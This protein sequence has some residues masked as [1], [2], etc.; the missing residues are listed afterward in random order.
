VLSGFSLGHADLLRRAM[1]KKIKAEM[2]A[3]RRSFGDGAM[4]R[5]VDEARAGRIFD[6]VDKFA[7]YGFNKSHAAAYALVA[8]QTAWLKANHPVEF[9][10]AS[11]TLDLGNTD[12]LNVFRQELTRLAIPLLP[13]D[14]NDSDVAF[15]VRAPRSEGEPG[16]IRYALAAVKNV[17]AGAMT[18]VVAERDRG[19]P[20]RD[21]FDFAERVG[22]KVANKRQLENLV[23]A[24]A[25]D[26]LDRNRRRLFEGAETLIRLAGAAERERGT[27]QASLFGGEAMLPAQ[28]TQLPAVDDWPAMER[29]NH[30]FDAVGFYLSAHPLDAYGRALDRLGVVSHDRLTPAAA[31]TRPKLVGVVVAKRERTSAKGN[32]FAF[33]QLSDSHGVFEVV[34]FSEVLTASR[35]LLDSGKPLL[36]TCEV[37]ADGEGVRLNAQAVEDLDEAV[38]RSGQGLKVH[39]DRA[40]GLAALKRAVATAKRG[41]GRLSLVLDIDQAQSVEIALPGAYAISAE[42]RAAIGSVPGVVGLHDI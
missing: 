11:M 14:I 34:M 18:A 13:P 42:M 17:G 24:G 26:S 31:G 33:V 8:Y 22:A 19:G 6:L 3:Q 37:R 35:A 23:R 16:T 30:E 12:K 29:L 15:A 36:L 10:A 9:L 5:G 1:G 41:R 39:L 25:F 2:E 32:R 27:S 38:A 7:G 28:R 4:A 40:E 20:F 21:P